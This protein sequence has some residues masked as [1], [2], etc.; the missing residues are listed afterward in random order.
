MGK[1]TRFQ[2]DDIAQLVLSTNTTTPS[3]DDLDTDVP[4]NC[5]L[6]DDTLLENI[7]LAEGDTQAG[8]LSAIQLAVILAVFRFERRTEHCDELFME[9]ADA[10]LDKVIN[11]R[12][13]W[14]VQTAALL[15]RCELERT[16]NRRVE[17]ACAQSELIC[18]LM[19]G[20][21]KTAEDVRIK[22]CKLVLASG[23]DPFWEAHVIHAETLRSLGCTSECL[24]IYEKLEMWDNVINCFKQLGQLEKAEALIRKLLVNRPNDSMLYCYLGDITLERSYYDKA[25]EVS[26]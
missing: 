1:R 13:C 19:D 5:A 9:R 18:K 26:N 6:N 3:Q 7:S 21:D 23:L 17:R 25:I 15:A 4:A 2:K 14:P 11:Q 16:K 10:F 22:R 20:D 24:L 8:Y 12:R